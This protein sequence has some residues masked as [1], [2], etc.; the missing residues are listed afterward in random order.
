V[1]RQNS[2][3]KTSL[4]KLNAFGSFQGWR[5]RDPGGQAIA[6]RMGPRYSYTGSRD[7]IGTKVIDS[8][9]KDHELY[10]LLLGARLEE[11]IVKF[12]STKKP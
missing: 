1:T 7:P 10:E 11:V 8:T 3:G 4:K 9:L 12:S 6:L 5:N 2:R